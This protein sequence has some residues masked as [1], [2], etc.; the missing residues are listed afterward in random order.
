MSNWQHYWK[1]IL[2]FLSLV[3]TNAVTDLM[4]DG[5]PWPSTGGEWAR[6]GVSILGGTL[7][8]YGKGNAPKPMPVDVAVEDN[9][10]TIPIEVPAQSAP[11]RRRVI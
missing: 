8:V 6:W 9:P 5:S 11:R 1:A 2:A 3:A 10:P 7:V 4:Q